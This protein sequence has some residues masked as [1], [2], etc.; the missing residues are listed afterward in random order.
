[1]TKLH[2]R[3]TAFLLALVASLLLMNAT[4]SPPEA[5]KVDPAAVKI[6]QRMTDYVSK[7]QQFSVHTENTLEDVLDSGQRIDFDVAANVIVRRPNKL[8]AE[9][10]G[11]RI[12]QAFYY[13]GKS[14]T[15]YRPSEGVYATQQ[16][17]G[18]I[19][20]LLDYVREELGL[21]IPVSDLVYRNA[22]AILMQDVHSAV[23]VG[24][25]VIGG[26][27]CDHLAFSRPD[28]DFQV[29]VADGNDPLPCK[30][31]VTDT[32]TPELIST[33]SVMSNWNLT[34][35]PADADF[36]FMPP[37][38]AKAITFMPLDKTSGFGR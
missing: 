22:F 20:E 14:L 25:A 16:A 31:V 8:R 36:K 12:N 23:V 21:D 6:L 4:E 30:Y 32:S 35:G 27:T 7:L 37:E 38:G 19:E 10:I 28:V 11:E 13:D 1:M 2:S 9:R 18:S 26:I 5:A 33:V 17:P 34:P 29:W 3:I 24:K 15:L